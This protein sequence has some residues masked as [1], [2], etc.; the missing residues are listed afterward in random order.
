MTY[1]EEDTN[2]DKDPPP[3][4]YSVLSIEMHDREGKKTR[5]GTSKRG[6]AEHHGKAELHGMT[7]VKGGKEEHDSRKE[8]T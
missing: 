6:D 8:T 1:I 2:D 4:S 7:L 3:A 5:E